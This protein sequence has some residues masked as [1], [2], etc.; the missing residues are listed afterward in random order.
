[1]HHHG[2]AALSGF[3][4]A[5]QR[6]SPEVSGLNSCSDFDASSCLRRYSFFSC[7]KEVACVDVDGG[8]AY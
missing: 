7:F 2:A 3:E 4:T 8:R 5:L 1:V 6:I